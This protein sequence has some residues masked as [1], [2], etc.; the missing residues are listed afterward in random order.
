MNWISK[1]MVAVVLAVFAGTTAWAAQKPPELV[2]TTCSLCHGIN[3]QS[4]APT[5][6]NLA[7]QTAPYLESQLKAF[8]DHSRSDPHAQA[9]MWGMASQLTEA[10]IKSVA[11]Y[12][13]KL[14]PAPGTAQDPAQVAA[15]RRIFEHGVPSR[16]IPACSA[17]HGAEG[18]GN[19][20]IP[21]LAGQ[22]RDY[23]ATQLLAFKNELRFNN[24]MHQNV[25]DMTNA[26]VRD[27]SAYLA[28]K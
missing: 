4:T 1:T 14:P 9:Y 20:P 19:G 25:A 21:R 16:H 13:S 5:F 27:V 22:H 10:N 7:A 2:T 17:C 8:R 15:G 18:Q 12:F 23:L 26:E 11:K 3:G 6:P 24:V 28:S